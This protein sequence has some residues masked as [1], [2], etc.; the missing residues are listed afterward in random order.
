MAKP[1]KDMIVD[2]QDGRIRYNLV[3]RGG[4][5]VQ[6]DV[7]LEVASTVLQQGDT[8]GAKEMNTFI[9]RSDDGTVLTTNFYVQE[10]F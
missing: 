5:V 7:A 8:Y 9:T 4:D 6:A 2:E 10:E 1:Y 3:G